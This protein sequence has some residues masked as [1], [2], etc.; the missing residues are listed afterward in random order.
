[1]RCFLAVPLPEGVRGQVSALCRTLRP[2]LPG[3]RF[4]TPDTMH[5][6]LHFFEDLDEAQVALAREAA[7]EGCAAVPGFE[8][9]LGG[10]GAFPDPRRARV[11]WTGVTAGAAPLQALQEAVGA[12][13][14]ARG[15][16]VDDRPWRPHLTLARFR[17]PEPAV[18]AC[19]PAGAAFA[20]TPFPVTESVLFGSRLS[21]VGAVHTPLGRFALR[22]GP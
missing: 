18:E 17:L 19:L 16:P 13:L 4:V 1:M 9:A 8:V 20:P 7:A 12:G 2:R 6:T 11:L 21:Q 3:A 22:T 15:L 10:L 14:A 5:L